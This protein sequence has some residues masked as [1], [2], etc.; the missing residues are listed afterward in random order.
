MYNCKESQIDRTWIQTQRVCV[1]KFP[2]TRPR[3]DALCEVE[4]KKEAMRAAWRVEN[5]LD[6]LQSITLPSA[7]FQA[8]WKKTGAEHFLIT[9]KNGGMELLEK[10][11][12][13][14]RGGVSCIFQPTGLANNW[15][16]LP[17]E[18]EVAPVALVAVLGR[19]CHPIGVHKNGESPMLDCWML[20]VEV[21]A[22]LKR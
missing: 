20:R 6:L 8:M 15:K 10:L 9:E 3:V 19:N 17:P 7:S 11:N 2:T 21:S 22:R 5:G 13:N 14:I 16:A 4:A 1:Q 12:E 18:C